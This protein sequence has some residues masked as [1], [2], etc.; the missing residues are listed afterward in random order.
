MTVPQSKFPSV[1]PRIPA[2]LSGLTATKSDT[3]ALVLELCE[4]LAEEQRLATC[5]ATIVGEENSRSLYDR[6]DAPRCC[7]GLTYALKRLVRGC[8][9][10]KDASRT[11]CA[12][13]LSVLSD[14]F[15]RV[16]DA[17]VLLKWTDALLTADMVGS[18]KA[19][20]DGRL[21]GMG[22][23]LVATVI[24]NSR[25]MAIDPASET[26]LLDILL[27]LKF[28][29]SYFSLPVDELLFNAR[30][31][32]PLDKVSDCRL[33][34]TLSGVALGRAEFPGL[35]ALL[36]LHREEMV[37]ALPRLH[38]ALAALAR[39]KGMA[40]EEDAASFLSDSKEL[41]LIALLYLRASTGAV[42]PPPQ[43][44]KLAERT[45]S[46]K[47]PKGALDEHCRSAISDIIAQFFKGLSELDP[48]DLLMALVSVPQVLIKRHLAVLSPVLQQLSDDD[49]AAYCTAARA[50]GHID[51]FFLPLRL[52]KDLSPAIVDAI[53]DF[54]ISL[55]SSA[56][57]RIESGLSSVSPLLQLCTAISR[58]FIKSEHDS[59][60]IRNA[61]KAFKKI[62]KTSADTVGRAAEVLL[63]ILVVSGETECIELLEDL[64]AVSKSN[65]ASFITELILSL[66]SMTPI[67]TR[68]L[69]EEIAKLAA[70]ADSL[71]LG[72]ILNVIKKPPAASEDFDLSAGDDQ[73]SDASME[74]D[75]E[76][77]EV[78]VPL[79]TLA[80][81]PEEFPASDLDDSDMEAI[82]AKLAEAVSLHIKA[83]GKAKEQKAQ[84]AN[85]G[86]I[87]Q[88]KCLGV[89]EAVS[90]SRGVAQATKL[91]HAAL[92]LDCLRSVETQKGSA[93]HCDRL[94]RVIKSLID[95]IKQV[96]ILPWV[97][98]LTVLLNGHG[99]GLKQISASALVPFMAAACK[100]VPPASVSKVVSSYLGCQMSSASTPHLLAAMAKTCLGPLA[101][102]AVDPDALA[103]ALKDQKSYLRGQL[104]H[105]LRACLLQRKSAQLLDVCCSSAID[106]LA[107]SLPSSKPAWIRAQ[108][109]ELHA[110]A[111]LGVSGSVREKLQSIRP[112][113]VDEAMQRQLDGVLAVAAKNGH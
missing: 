113:L 104:L 61:V 94:L 87:V 60:P 38:P 22:Y 37:S 92:V 107:A 65:M 71:D 8:A 21:I 34:S 77:A 85:L 35:S 17:G 5:D 105:S 47:R 99:G 11:V 14:V 58:N 1:D 36:Q 50:S 18:G 44:F 63:A 70:R 111:K 32:L 42:L 69:A 98:K 4:L 100:H 95:D 31:R 75:D 29:K 88:S 6:S 23:L 110:W 86:S 33:D 13:A 25:S 54:V 109:S 41:R 97:D 30:H 3:S 103:K 62:V 89:L 7:V 53:A 56:R 24:L 102:G 20:S 2:L 15:G 83:S 43:F 49:L 57:S 108:L 73:A 27:R 68:R 45:E 82:D 26:R 39:E 40:F 96:A 81:S 93:E 80:V 48:K 10:P 101:V 52:R 64:E 84:L 76:S 55:D 51:A 106:D 9:S 79:A 16:L 112:L 66:L 67:Y 78:G 91:E 46:C 90:R 28:K 59:E 74:I 72:P 19:K 12:W